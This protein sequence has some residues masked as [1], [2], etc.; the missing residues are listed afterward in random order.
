M[1]ENTTIQELQTKIEAL[2]N[3][4]ASMN[5]TYQAQIEQLKQSTSVAEEPKQEISD[6]EAFVNWFN[7]K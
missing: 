3:T 6:E 5:A 1:A 7:N 4:I 2:T